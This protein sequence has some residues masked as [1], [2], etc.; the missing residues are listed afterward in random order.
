MT[1]TDQGSAYVFVRNGATWTQQARLFAPDGASN[2]RF[3]FAVSI[4][5]DTALIGSPI[6]DTS[7]GSAYV[8]VRSGTT[9]T[10]QQKLTAIGGSVG[11]T[12]R[13]GTRA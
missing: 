12:V 13:H 3:G 4:D 7:K 5:G 1:E 6:D 10:H 9:W 2:D 11:R 8:F